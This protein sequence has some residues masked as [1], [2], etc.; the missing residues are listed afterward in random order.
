MLGKLKKGC[1]QYPP[2]ESLEI[3]RR[4][5]ILKP[6]KYH[7]KDEGVLRNLNMNSLFYLQ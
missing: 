1:L 7:K 4:K 3:E 2:L 6:L 5:E